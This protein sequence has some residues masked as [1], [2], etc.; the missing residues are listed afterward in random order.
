MADTVLYREERKSLGITI[1]LAV[2]TLAVAAFFF[3][4]LAYG[5]LGSRP[6]PNWILGILTLLFLLA[7]INFR[8]ITL[9]L[10]D[11]GMKVNYGVF[12]A[13]LRWEDITHCGKDEKNYFYGGWGIRLGRYEGHWVTVYNVIGGSRVVFLTGKNKPKGLIVS[14]LNPEEIARIAATKIRAA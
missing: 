9:V 3:A 12:G 8:K 11:S 6:A 5:P 2:V 1:I 14:T 4:Q 10:T 7:A 13:S